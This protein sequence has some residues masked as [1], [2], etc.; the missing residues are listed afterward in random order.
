MATEKEI[1]PRMTINTQQ[2]PNEPVTV[3]LSD[4]ANDVLVSL[5]D[6]GFAEDLD[7]Y[8]F[9]VALAIAHGVDPSAVQLTKRT[10]KYNI[11]TLDPD[12]SLYAAAKML[13]TI[14][15]ELPVYSAIERLAEW[16]I[17]E[18]GK[19]AQ[20]SFPFSEIDSELS[21]ISSSD[22]KDLS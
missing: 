7:A 4:E 14:P 15:S 12:R 19:R 2:T 21:S 17:K 18:L 10:T 9:G 13:V 16:G 1:A 11:G 5:R 20:T 22:E 3:G 8:R 6:I